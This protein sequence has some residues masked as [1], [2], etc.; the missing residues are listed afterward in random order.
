[1]QALVDQLFVRKAASDALSRHIP[2]QQIWTGLHPL[3]FKCG[4]FMVLKAYLDESY[5][6]DS[7]F[8][9]CSISA[10]G[11]DW[12]WMEVAWKRVLKRKNGELE[13]S[14]RRLLSGFHAADCNARRN[15]FDGWSETERD[16]FLADLRRCFGRLRE[17]GRVASFSIPVADFKRAFG[18]LRDFQEPRA[19]QKMLRT[20]HGLAVKF[21]MFE[22]CRDYGENPI[23]LQF[24]LI[25][26]R[27]DCH[28]AQVAA[29]NSQLRD[30]GF[31]CRAM[32]PSIT[33]QER[34]SCFPLQIADMVA[35]ET[36]KETE[37]IANGL[38]GARR[39]NLS[40]LIR[41]PKL[42]GSAARLSPDNLRMMRLFLENRRAR[43]AA[44]DASRAA[45]AS[46]H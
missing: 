43:H 34:K 16:A 29:F 36:F 13:R 25:C 21:L 38:G 46:G 18:D 4:A 33:Q 5:R 22:L 2:V 11:F 9:L 3:G 17:G 42:S 24:A 45:G 23:P 7:I 1:M 41:I 31:G 20:W 30:P 12:K 8:T 37:R 32:F 28:P 26:D 44:S 39:E 19:T 10:K 35:Y 6:S 14:G 40:Q 27:S 15:E